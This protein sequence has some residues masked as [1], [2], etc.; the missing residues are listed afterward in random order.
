MFAVLFQYRLKM[1][2]HNCFTLQS[3]VITSNPEGMERHD[4][5]P[6]KVLVC[7]CSWVPQCVYWLGKMLLSLWLSVMSCLILRP[8]VALSASE[9]LTSPC[10][11]RNTHSQA[12]SQNYWI[13]VYQSVSKHGSVWEP[14]FHTILTFLSTPQSLRLKH[15]QVPFVHLTFDWLLLGASARYKPLLGSQVACFPPELSLQWFH[16]HFA[17]LRLQFLEGNWGDE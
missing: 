5:C 2:L 12:L 16:L 13:T 8:G 11:P 10:W 1:D 3:N 7:V 9:A 15:S 4:Q 14:L 6:Y 17:P